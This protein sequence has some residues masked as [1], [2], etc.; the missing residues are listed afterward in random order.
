[1]SGPRPRPRAWG[2]APD[3]A[4]TV[5]TVMLAN[6][7]MTAA[8]TAGHGAELARHL[9]LSA[10]GAVVVKSLSAEPWAGNPAPRVHPTDGGM[11]NSVGLQNP[12]VPA[13]LAEELPALAATVLTRVRAAAPA[14]RTAPATA[15]RSAVLGLSLAHS[16][17][18]Q[19][20]TASTTSA[21]AAG[22]W[23]NIR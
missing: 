5:G 17:R 21:A 16:G 1:M 8:G 10:L 3:M 7:V 11:L 9:D 20:V 23:A 13:W 6:P 2:R 12:G 4:V 18:P 15:T 22:S 14:S 19:A